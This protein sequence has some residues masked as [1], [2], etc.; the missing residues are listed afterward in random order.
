MNSK[1]NDEGGSDNDVMCCANC[2][3]AAVDDVKLKNCTACKL[4]KYCSVDCQKN[5]RPQHKKACRKRAA[6]LRED[7]LFQQP[8]GSCHGE[9][10]ICCLP[11]PLDESKSMVTSCC[12]KSICDGCV[13]A[14]RQREIEQRLEHKCPYC[15]EAIPKTQEEIEKNEK[16][17]VKANDPV[18][19]L[20]VGVKCDEEGDYEGAFQYFSKAAALGDVIAHY[21]LSLMYAKG[22]GVE[23]D[24]KKEL[25]H[26]EIAAIGGHHEAR[27]NLG[28]YDG[29]N[30]RYER[31]MKH[32]IIAANLGDDDALEEVKKGFVDGFVS[33]EDYAAALRGHKA[34]VDATKSE[35]RDAAYTFYQQGNQN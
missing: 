30:G 7:R 13:I 8:D 12:C 3:K 14:N 18:A 32:F 5:H 34:A 23:K 21:N 10:P 16:K 35:Q 27:F 28:C 17:R 4:V 22:E 25:H 6:E 29:S 11:L 33:K 1:S 20:K 24:T 2:G 26:L 31:A 19:L 15:R 9:C